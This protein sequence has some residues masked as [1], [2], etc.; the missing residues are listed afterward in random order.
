MDM[1]VTDSGAGNLLARKSKKDDV[2][3]E[4]IDLDKSFKDTLEEILVREIVDKGTVTFSDIMQY[5][6]KKALILFAETEQV[7][8]VNMDVDSVAIKMLIY[9]GKIYIIP[10][11]G[12]SYEVIL[13]DVQEDV[14]ICDEESLNIFNSQE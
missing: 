14:I 4:A 5:G 3:K 7:I 9:Y 2:N 10:H 8:H 12:G 13:N 11:K 1:F 6:I